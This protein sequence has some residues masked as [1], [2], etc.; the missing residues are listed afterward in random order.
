MKT[1]FA[2]S[3]TGFLHIGSMR[4]A[5]FAWLAA[6]SH[7]GEFYL[8]IED[9]DLQRSQSHYVDLIYQGLKWLGIDWD[10]SE[11]MIQSQRFP[12]YKEIA[13]SLVDN[14]HAYYCHCSKERLDDLKQDQM[15]NKLPIKYD[16]QCR[17]K[18][19]GYSDTAVLRLKVPN[20]IELKFT[21]LLHGEHTVTADVLDDWI[22]MRPGSVAT[23]NFSVVIDDNEMGVDTVIRGDDHLNNTPKQVLLYHLLGY[24][25]PTFCHMPMILDQQGARLSKRLGSANALHYKERGILP[26][27]LMNT[28]ARLGWSYG[29]EEVFTQQELLAKFSFAG[30]Q[31]SPACIDD[32]KL[33]WLN[34]QHIAMQ[35]DDNIAQT[36]QQ[37]NLFENKD[38]DTVLTVVSIFRERVETLLDFESM[39][40]FLF[41]EVEVSDDQLKELYPHYTGEIHSKVIDIVEQSES[42]DNFFK[43]LKQLAKDHQMK[44]PQVALPLRQIICGTT[45][46]PDFVRILSFLGK[47]KV[48]ARL[49]GVSL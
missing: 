17:D 18:N 9:T 42:F 31:K 3:P 24:E 11:P 46:A 2:P 12:L 23:Y 44:V 6:R 1:R 49:S 33:L 47:E 41:E 30:L 10:N 20:H 43:A 5:L 45:Q 35:S 32:Q 22:M 7:G 15:A 28:L 4:T 39:S 27:A 25:L 34:K 19:L 40:K 36:L 29:D 13:Q 38:T 26:E 37:L 16:R 21:D 8:R 14:G 48:M